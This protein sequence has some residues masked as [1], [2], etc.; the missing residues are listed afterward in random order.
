MQIDALLL[1]TIK[2]VLIVHRY[3]VV[4]KKKIIV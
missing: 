3:A 4:R 2:V 1:I